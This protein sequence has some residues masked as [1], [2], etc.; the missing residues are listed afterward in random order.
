VIHIAISRARERNEKLGLTGER[1]RPWLQA[2][3]IGA[4]KYG[5]Q[6]IQ[7]E[8]RAVYDSGYD[9]WVLWEPGSR[10]D[11]YIPAL[12]KT[13]LSRKKNPPVPRPAVRLD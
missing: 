10:Y 12:E 5:P 11:A 6:Q 4:P 7:D 2:F 8:K 1:V 13:L 9:G 3:S